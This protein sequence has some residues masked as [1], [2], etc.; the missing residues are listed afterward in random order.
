MT[1]INLDTATAKDLNDAIARFTAFKSLSDLH[2]SMENGYIPTL[3][4][5]GY[6]D[7]R[8][9]ADI[10]LIRAAL[11]QAKFPVFPERIPEIDGARMSEKSEHARIEAIQGISEGHV[12]V[13]WGK[14]VERGIG[15]N[16]KVH[17]VHSKWQGPMET[18]A[19][20]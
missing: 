1:T 18:I 8:D 6:A 2:A 19:H 9:R 4:L 14:V 15:L 10:A 13:L 5:D 17:G 16:F 12:K 3:R 7:A 11:I 20:L